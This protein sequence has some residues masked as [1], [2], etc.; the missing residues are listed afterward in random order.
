MGE[1]LAMTR[2]IKTGLALAAA[3][4]ALTAC[5]SPDQEADNTV[6]G[7]LRQTAAPA[8]SRVT[9]GGDGGQQAAAAPR[10]A[11][12]MAARALAANPAPL[13]L[14]NLESTG[15]TQV[16]AM[17]GENNGMRT[18]MTPNE[19]ALIMRNGMLIGTKGLGNDLS[20]AEAGNSAALIRSRRSGNASR[21]NRY[22][23]GDSVERP[24]P[25]SCTVASGETKSFA[26]AGRNWS[27]TQMVESCEA[28]GVSVQ[29]SYMVSP[30]GQIPV[31]RQW[32][33]PDLGYATI[34]TIRP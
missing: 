23:G 19:Q 31:S 6:L 26:F 12:D 8:L 33:S 5:G 1:I 20:V 7:Q 32:I 4:L 34:Q 29:N 2:V 15:A 3:A 25:M 13:I 28:G 22:I 18:Y 21:I 11:E 16:M 9:G 27:A 30:S 14:V 24:L 17:V 10:T